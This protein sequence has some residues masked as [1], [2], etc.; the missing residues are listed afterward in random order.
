[1]KRE[2]RFGGV[3]IDFPH[4]KEQE[5]EALECVGTRQGKASET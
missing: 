4:R 5:E 2:K 1:M 3:G